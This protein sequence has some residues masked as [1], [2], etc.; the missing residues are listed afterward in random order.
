MNE[1]LHL[2]IAF[3]SGLVVLSVI[4][5]IGLYWHIRKLEKL[6]EEGEKRD[7]GGE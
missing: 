3:A 5:I 6:A 7:K 2:L 4:L 1:A